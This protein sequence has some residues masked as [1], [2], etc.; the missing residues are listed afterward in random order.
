MKALVTGG[1][2]FIGSHLVEAL[3]RRGDKVRVLDNLSTGSQNNLAAVL[4]RVEFVQG[5]LRD[6]RDVERS[7]QG[8]D[9]VFHQ[10]ALR[11]VERSIHDPASSNA[12]NVD[13]TLKLLMACRQ[14]GV[15]RLIYAS[16]SS[17]YGD[18]KVFPQV[19]TMRASPLSPYA[20]SKASA[21]MYCVVFA[22]TFGLQT[23]SLRYFNVFGP[24]QSPESQYAAVIPK[25]M[26]SALQETPLEVHWDGR[27]SRD[28]TYIDNVAE[29]N[30]LAAEAPSASGEVFNIACGTSHSLLDIIR[31]LGKLSG[32]PLARKH[33]PAR[34]G[35]TRKTWADVRKAKKTLRYRPRIGFEEGLRRTWEWFVQTQRRKAL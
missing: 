26:Q 21:E 14:A 24:R 2:G 5:D 17:V 8:M 12:V 28:F 9:C 25:F 3:L 23:V 1:A 27:Q 15:K 6:G 22:K 13:G 33:F 29:A 31:E 18:N 11:S 30:L 7:V 34:A 19:E 32:H 16:S 35:D 10:A 4:D 20:V